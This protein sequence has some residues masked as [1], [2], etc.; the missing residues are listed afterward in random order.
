MITK[1]LNLKQSLHAVDGLLAALQQA[2]GA[3]FLLQVF[4]KALSSPVI[5]A[6]QKEIA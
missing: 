3:C 1:L 2:N 6:I 5:S 4:V